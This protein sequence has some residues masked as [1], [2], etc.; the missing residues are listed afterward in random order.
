[1]GA[2]VS[3]YLD[4]RVKKK[5]NSFPLK[6]RVTHDRKRYYISLDANRVNNVLTGRLKHFKYNGRESFSIDKETFDKTNQQKPRGI[7]KELQTVFRA[8]ELEYQQ[9]AD[10]FN[11]FTIEKFKEQFS[12]K[13]R[14]VVNDVFVQIEKKA[15]L[16]KEENRFNSASAYRSTL[17]SLKE[18]NCK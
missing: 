1:M 3:L 8:F 11:P 14:N 16:L 5:D 2:T 13:N 17:S 6:I 4:E 15:K 9:L 7:Y 12:D 10:S 18:F